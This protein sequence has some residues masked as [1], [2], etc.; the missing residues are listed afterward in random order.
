MKKQTAIVVT[1][2]AGF[3]GCNVARRLKESGYSV[4]AID[5]LSLGRASNLPPDIPLLVGDAGDARVWRKVPE[6]ACIVHLAGAS[7]TPLFSKDLVGAFGNNVC[8]FLH[9]LEEA[10]V[11]CIPRVIY[12]STSLIYGNTPCLV[13][14]TGPSDPL[15]FYA[16]SKQ[17]MEDVARLHERQFGIECIGLRLMSVY[18]P[19]EDHKRDMANL[20]SQ[21]IWALEAGRAPIVYGD[22][23]Q[24]RDF[25]S[26]WDVAQAIERLH[27]HARPLGARLF[28]V[29]TGHAI[30]VNELIRILARIMGVKV[31]PEYVP[32]PTA[33][34]YN[35][36]QYASLDLIKNEIGYTPTVLLEQGI[37]E[38][39]TLR[40][41]TVKAGI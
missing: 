1:G 15:N 14:E 9:V 32:L 36:H 2:A 40:R 37:E 33:R 10:R 13:R 27:V 26:V 39:L 3:I 11:R 34:A 20:V 8:S 29:G 18:G 28:N 16:L 17:A 22:G 25:T 35:Q 31:K 41:W 7:S 24:T 19:R 6:V 4:F 21:F 5:N 12:A 30:T 23:S 38:I